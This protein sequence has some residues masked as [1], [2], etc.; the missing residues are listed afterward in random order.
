[1]KKNPFPRIFPHILTAALLVSL[2]ACAPAAAPSQPAEEE[3]ETEAGQTQPASS[4]PEA[5]AENE[6]Q[7]SQWQAEENAPTE[8]EV[9]ALRERVLEGVS[10]EDA[11]YMKQC[12]QTAN[13]R[14]ESGVVYGDLWEKLSDPEGLYW[15]LFDKTGEI[16]IA[17]AFSSDVGEYEDA[18]TDMTKKEY[19]ETYGHPVI[20]ENN[21]DAEFFANLMEEL[22]S[23]TKDEALQKDF[24]AMIENVKMAKETH[25]VS[26]VQTL[27][28]QLHDMDYFLLHYG[29][30]Y[31]VYYTEDDS[32]IE[33]YYGVLHVY[34]D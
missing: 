16:Q 33:K 22:K 1:M 10:E 15:N 5:S 32:V 4:A 21:S 17:W 3:T 24:D 8:E 23:Y 12:I 34:A 26:Y 14:L 13:L 31:P 28:E 2:T 6:S 29:P 20:V 9:T 27:Y 25:E 19:E 18:D 7:A 11:A 30:E